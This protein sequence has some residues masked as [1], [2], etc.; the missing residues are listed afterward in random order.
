M[1]GGATPRIEIA[2]FVE[3]RR[4]RASGQPR[5]NGIEIG[6]EIPQIVHCPM[7]A[8]ARYSNPTTS[9]Y[10]TVIAAIV[11]G[12]VT[13]T[14]TNRHSTPAMLSSPRAIR[15]SVYPR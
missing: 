7:L 11:M 13:S 15:N 8:H 2:E 12:I 6:P 14:P 1:D 3:R 4:I 5:G 9:R 10:A